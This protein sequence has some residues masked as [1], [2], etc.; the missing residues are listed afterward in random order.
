MESIITKN[1]SFKEK[2]LTIFSKKKNIDTI[3]SYDTKFP[4]ISKYRM[5]SNKNTKNGQNKEHDNKTLQ[6]SSI[7]RSLKNVALSSKLYGNYLDF[8]SNLSQR[9][10]L[11]TS[12]TNKCFLF[13]KKELFINKSATFQFLEQGKNSF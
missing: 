10:S 12:R 7:S 13:K 8:Y 1:Y 9:H 4:E 6:I 5:P 2:Q 11:K 3:N